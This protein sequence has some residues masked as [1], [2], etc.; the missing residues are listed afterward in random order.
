M[1][2]RFTTAANGNPSS[3]STSLVDMVGIEYGLHSS[4]PPRLFIIHKRQRHSRKDVEILASY[5][6]LDGTIY[7]APSLLALLKCR[8]ATSLEYLTGAIGMATDNLRYDPSLKQY[9]SPDLVLTADQ[10]GQDAAAEQRA[11]SIFNAISSFRNQ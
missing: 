2:T 5:Y 10:G 3:I 8:V 7:Q 9:I 4:H 1:Q 6:I 11:L